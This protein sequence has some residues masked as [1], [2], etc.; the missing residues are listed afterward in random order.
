MADNNTLK[1]VKVSSHSDNPDTTLVNPS[2]WNHEHHF[3]NGATG[4]V[5]KWDSTKTDNVT[6]GEAIDTS[7][8]AGLPGPG[9]TG[10]LIYVT[11][12][13]KGLRVDNGNILAPITP[14]IDVVEFAGS[15]S[16]TQAD[17]W[18][19][20]EAAFGSIVS[21][22]YF[23]IPNTSY[24]F[25]SGWFKTPYTM[26]PTTFNVIYGTG[27][28]TV[29]QYTGGTIGVNI[30]GTPGNS[31]LTESI[32][33][34]N[35]SL[36]STGGTVGISVFNTS[37][38]KMH[39]VTIIGRLQSGDGI[40]GWLTA[41]L[42]IDSSVGGFS[43]INFFSRV[44]SGNLVGDA[45]RFGSGTLD[46]ENNTFV[47]CNFFAAGGHCINMAQKCINTTFYGCE[48]ENSALSC[49]YAHYFWNLSFYSC[50]FENANNVPV[51]EIGTFYNGVA[52]SAGPFT[53]IDNFVINSSSGIALSIGTARNISGGNISGNLFL[54]TGGAAYA[55]KLGTLIS[56][57]IGGNRGNI[58]NFDYSTALLDNCVIDDYNNNFTGGTDLTHIVWNH[59]ND[60]HLKLMRSSNLS[61]ERM[62]IYFGTIAHPTL[63]KLSGLNIDQ[64][65]NA[66]GIVATVGTGV[67]TTIADVMKLNIFG[68]AANDTA[69]MLYDITAGT[70]QRVTIGIANSG[71]AGFRLLRI[72]N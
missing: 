67:G 71:G 3:N 31:A 27:A 68:T 4:Q 37:G 65:L 56:V 41:G 49:V 54:P 25:C 24:S 26:V 33:M 60:T 70:L 1:H 59:Y 55:I 9:R 23:G 5:L 64:T 46:N 40:T 17:P 45:L 10:R 30:N 22:N 66:G 72:P 29:I 69:M 12:G 6:F 11:D 62:S 42:L 53:F 63:A 61:N 2:D 58:R 57:N 52:D 15:G 28:N 36:R 16:G 32:Q 35:F 8:T 34:S 47:Q 21:N 20:W 44:S 19:G 50:A 48:I 18:L 51:L 39:N 7:T 38:L 14:I 13:K 43:V